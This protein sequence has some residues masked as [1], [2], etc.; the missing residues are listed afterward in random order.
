M[1]FWEFRPRKNAQPAILPELDIVNHIIVPEHI[2]S[3]TDKA[4]T[5]IHIPNALFST[6][7]TR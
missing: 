3:S 4:A 1:R 6:K 2:C 5:A 7:E